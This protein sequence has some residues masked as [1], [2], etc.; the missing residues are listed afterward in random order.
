[1][2]PTTTPRDEPPAMS[3]RHPGVA[4]HAPLRAGVAAP[5]LATEQIDMAPLLADRD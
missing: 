5:I 2:M 1:M 3:L 4:L